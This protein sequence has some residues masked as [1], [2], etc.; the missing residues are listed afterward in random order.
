VLRC[1]G[2]WC[3]V[4]V[5]LLAAGAVVGAAGGVAWAGSS[6]WRVGLL[7]AGSVLAGVSCP[8]AGECWAAGYSSAKG[9]YDAEVVHSADG[10]AGWIDELP[11]KGRNYGNLGGVSCGSVK[12]CLAYGGDIRRTTDGG[13]S[14]PY[15]KQPGG[16]ESTDALTC[17]T[18]ADCWVAGGVMSGAATIY[19]TTDGGSSWH[20]QTTLAGAAMVSQIACVGT[21]DCWA[22][23]S[24][25]I[26]G[27]QYASNAA[28]W[29]TTDGGQSWSSL[30]LPSGIET[31]TGVSCLSSTDCVVMGSTKPLAPVAPTDGGVILVTSDGGAWWTRQAPP[32]GVDILG[33]VSC[34]KG[35]RSCA[36][37][38]ASR[39][40]TS[41]I[42]VTSD[43]G[44]SWGVA[45]TL[46]GV[47]LVSVSCPTVTDCVAV[48]GGT[49]TY[50][51][52]LPAKPMPVV[53]PNPCQLPAAALD[54]IVGPGTTPADGRVV[55]TNRKTS[56]ET[57]TCRFPVGYGKYPGDDFRPAVYVGY[58]PPNDS[59]LPPFFPYT[60]QPVPG[61]PGAKAVA[62]GQPIQSDDALA[63]IF[64]TFTRRI[65]NKVVYG[66]IVTTFNT[67]SWP[68]CTRSGYMAPVELAAKDLYKA[69]Y[70]GASVSVPPVPPNCPSTG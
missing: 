48:G 33:T 25:A 34:V 9:G 8:V 35:T 26:V 46:L 58:L 57:A 53:L 63:W 51:P 18:A 49:A 45:T 5:A 10:G 2:R 59:Y 32:G 13:T 38:A 42:I 19:A 68:S 6:G 44:Q 65:G 70:P 12:V 24:V 17:A 14:W 3:G 22:V 52:I 66:Q 31:L 55:W 54:D 11:V 1:G 50:G 23:G 27:Q 28:G 67:D 43:A 56:R 29:R 37:I 47:N 30:A 16:L 62:T 60:A 15:L 40:G 20:L 61:F 64:V 21:R 7:P 4:V 69:I 41:Y 39:A 36:A